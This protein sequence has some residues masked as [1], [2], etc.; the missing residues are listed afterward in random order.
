MRVKAAVRADSLVDFPAANKA[1]QGPPAQAERTL[2]LADS[3]FRIS[4]KGGAEKRRRRQVRQGAEGF[5][6]CLPAIWIAV[7]RD[8][9]RKK[10]QSRGRASSTRSM[11]RS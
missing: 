7:G 6:K 4:S 2:T 5:A 3:T 1:M 11:F 8:P 10:H 9:W